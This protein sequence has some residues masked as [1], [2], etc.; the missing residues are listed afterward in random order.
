MSPLLNVTT[1][2]QRSPPPTP[3][4]NTPSRPKRPRPSRNT[5]PTYR[6]T[7]HSSEPSPTE[8]TARDK[9]LR[10]RAPKATNSRTRGFPTLT[11]RTT[12]NAK[13]PTVAI[14]SPSSGRLTSLRHQFQVIGGTL[15]HKRTR[16]AWGAFRVPSVGLPM[17]HHRRSITD[18]V[19]IV[20]DGFLWGSLVRGNVD[21]V[22]VW[23][24][25]WILKGRERVR[26]G[27]RRCL[28]G[29]RGRAL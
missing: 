3:T 27:M 8:K 20:W 16:A 2:S 13:P 4:H 6:S 19:W 18:R 1:P 11:T 25:V 28:G 9:S 26:S 22:E 29:R 14:A 24:L 10:V 12:S 23:R 7:H 15:R 21:I 17:L 5:S